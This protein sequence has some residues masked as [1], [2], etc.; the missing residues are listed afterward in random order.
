[1]RKTIALNV[2]IGVP[3]HNEEGNIGLLLTD[4]YNQKID[5]NNNL[6]LVIVLDRCSDDT[7][8]IISSF[9]NKLKIKIL[10]TNDQSGYGLASGQNL[11]LQNTKRDSI[12][13]LL[14]ADIRIHDKNLI[15][16]IVN[17]ILKGNDLVSVRALPNKPMS[18]FQNILFTGHIFKWDIFEK[19]KDGHNLYTCCG[20][21]RGFSAKACQKLFFK[22]TAGEDAYSYLE[23]VKQKLNF[24]FSFPQLAKNMSRNL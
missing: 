13:I 6:E 11:I 1:M 5:K 17:E 15:Q 22:D 16:A 21:A 9:Q 23:I 10:Q 3:A 19:W 7:F 14:N 20:V 2:T 8:D 24:I 4:I 18:Y 12:L